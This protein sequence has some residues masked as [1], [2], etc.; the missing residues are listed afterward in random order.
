M[1]WPLIVLAGCS[2]ADGD[3]TVVAHRAAA[4]YWPENSATAVEESVAAGFE[5]IE[6]DLALTADGVPVLSRFPWLLPDRCTDRDGAPLPDRVTIAEVAWDELRAQYRCGGLADPEHVNSL[7]IS[8]PLLS[9]SALITALSD[10]DPRAMLV[11]DVHVEEPDTLP[12][13]DFA[14][15]V[16]DRLYAADLP[17]PWMVT[18]DR[19]EVLAAFREHG[20]RIGHHVPNVLVYPRMPLDPDAPAEPTRDQRS[21]ATGVSY[22]DL[23]EEAGVDGILVHW[24]LANRPRLQAASGAGLIT[25]LWTVDDAD[26]LRHHLTW[27]VDLVLTAYPGDAR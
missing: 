20:R 17:N 22:V 8:E 27:P 14:A 5:G 11:L 12:A 7:R 18:S 24:E 13:E 6:V 9:L 25:G 2:A 16:L 3:P 4:G 21:S 19:P 15:A 10:G 1:R 23:V 26:A